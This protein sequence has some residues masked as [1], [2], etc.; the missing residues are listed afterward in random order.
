MEDCDLADV[1]LVTVYWRQY[2]IDIAQLLCVCPTLEKINYEDMLS[3]HS[4]DHYFNAVG[5]S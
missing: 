3:S 5:T 2:H 4:P 1:N